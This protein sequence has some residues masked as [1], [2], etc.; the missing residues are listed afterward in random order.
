M[1]RASTTIGSGSSTC[2]NAAEH[3]SSRPADASSSASSAVTTRH[4]TPWH[5]PGCA[6]TSASSGKRA[7]AG[8]S[9]TCAVHSAC[10]TADAMMLTTKTS[11]DTALTARCSTCLRLT[12]NQSGDRKSQCNLSVGKH[13]KMSIIAH[14]GKGRKTALFA[15]ILPKGREPALISS[16]RVGQ[17]DASCEP[18]RREAPTGTSPRK[19]VQ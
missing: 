2:R 7:G 11:T 1:L 5:W 16:R 3:R 8:H 10:W 12:P 17:H 13:C 6:T 15:M 4:R 19:S 18:S 14:S 9:E